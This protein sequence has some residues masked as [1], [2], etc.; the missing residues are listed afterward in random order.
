MIGR[1]R[2]RLGPLAEREFALLF[3]ATSITTLGDRLGHIALAFAVLELPGGGARELGLVLA[4][5]IGVE[6]L[7]VVG[8]GVLADRLPRSLILVGASTIQAVAQAAIAALVLTGTATT[9]NLIALSI[10]YGIGG[11]LVIPAEIGLVPQTVSTGRL[12][13]ANA[14][15]GLSRNAVSLLG[16]AV[17]GALIVAGSPGTALAVDAA[18]FAVCAVLLSRIRIAVRD[19]GPAR[20]HFLQEL[21]GGWREFRQ[22]DWLWSSVLLFGISNLAFTGCWGVLGPVVAQERLGGAGAWATVLAAAGVGSVVGGIFALRYRPKRPLLASVLWAWPLML[23]V[24]GLALAVPVWMLA[25]C[26]FATGLGLAVHL[27]LWFTVLQREIP[28]HA[29]S[30]VSSF[31]VLGSFVLIPVGMAIAGPVSEAIGVTPTLWAGL[32]V[33]LA[34]QLAIVAVPSVRRLRDPESAPATVGAG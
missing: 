29:Q 10:L 14:L 22:R 3:T 2:G 15:L 28:E 17:G 7:V 12:Q 27:A 11:G 26:A 5:R 25:L 8:G 16:P 9:G 24:L 23:E 19:G 20:E 4:T 33:M 13:Q 30:R 6:S 32:A 18:T 1:F 34:M 31:D 21:R